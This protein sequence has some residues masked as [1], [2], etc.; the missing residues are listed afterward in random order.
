MQGMDV[1]GI[2]DDG[3]AQVDHVGVSGI[4]LWKF[5]PV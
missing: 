1:F 5:I 2:G 4:V 3:I